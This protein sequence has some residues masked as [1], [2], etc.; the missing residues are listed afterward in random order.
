MRDLG[1]TV[2]SCF[3]SVRPCV[4]VF[5][6]PGPFFGV[7]VLQL[8]RSSILMFMEYIMNSKPGWPPNVT[9]DD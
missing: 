1:Y 3:H 6:R 8:R 4:R 5:V 2:F 7:F 9:E